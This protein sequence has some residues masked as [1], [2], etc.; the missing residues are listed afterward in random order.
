MRGA[1]GLVDTSAEFDGDDLAAILATPGTVNARIIN[2]MRFKL[3]YSGFET[4]F[5]PSTKGAEIR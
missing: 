4:C 1:F 5:A 3:L 2:D